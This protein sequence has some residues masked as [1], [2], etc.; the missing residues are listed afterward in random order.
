M[1]L[2]ELAYT[3]KNGNGAVIRA[4]FKGS[5]QIIFSCNDRYTRRTCGNACGHDLRHLRNIRRS[6]KQQRRKE[7]RC[8]A[9]K[10]T[11]E[12]AFH[13]CITFLLE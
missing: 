8:C 2:R 9:S 10:R 4:V 6:S 1:F 11:F 13:W 7:Y 5:F 12:F 3:E